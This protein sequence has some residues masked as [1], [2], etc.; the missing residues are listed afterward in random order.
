V[1]VKWLVEKMTGKARRETGTGSA[2]ATGA[3]ALAARRLS[4]AARNGRPELHDIALHLSAGE[5]VGVYGLMG[6]GRTELLEHLAG[7]HAEGSGEVELGRM[8]LDGKPVHER[9]RAGMIL[10]PEDRQAAGLVQSLDVRANVTLANLAS[11][12]RAGYLSPAREEAAAA[13]LITRLRIKTS[14]GDQPVTSLS[15]GNQQ[16]VVMAKCLFAA[17]KVLLLDEPTRGVDVGARAEI[18]DVMR[19]LAAEGMSILFTSSELAEIFAV[20]T[21]ILVLAGGRI[22][23]D[24]AAAETDEH[25]LVAASSQA[26]Q[27]GQGGSHERG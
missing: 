21:R 4:L 16:K 10:V 24:Y 9:I 26:F 25:T 27:N 11:C 12:S 3:P 18:Y 8:R 13:G 20:A 15:G 2:A 19:A 23:G 7:L 5:I 6:S 17:P 1:D 14:G 22:T